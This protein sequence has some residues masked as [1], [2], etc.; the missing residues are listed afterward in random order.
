MRKVILFFKSI[1][2]PINCA[3]S[4][5][6]TCPHYFPYNSITQAAVSVLEFTILWLCITIWKRPCTCHKLIFYQ[7]NVK[8]HM[9]HLDFTLH[10][11]W[12]FIK[13]AHVCLHFDVETK[14]VNSV[15]LYCQIVCEQILDCYWH[16]TVCLNWLN[17]MNI[18]L[19]I[20][21]F[22]FFT[23]PDNLRSHLQ[24]FNKILHAQNIYFPFSIVEGCMI[25]SSHRSH[26]QKLWHHKWNLHG[27]LEITGF[28]LLNV[29]VQR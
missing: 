28:C 21:L 18:F 2:M 12:R 7:V 8:T 3:V 9:A 23:L 4:K 11:N 13:H 20:L 15:F 17:F 14:N 1:S 10:I 6:P 24:N 26:I 29:A 22:F 27:K 25:H 19:R 16:F 5:F